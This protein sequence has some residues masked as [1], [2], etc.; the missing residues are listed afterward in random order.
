MPDQ[1]CIAKYVNTKSSPKTTL[2]IYDGHNDEDETLQQHYY[3]ED[4]ASLRVNYDGSDPDRGFTEDTP[5]PSVTG[6]ED[7][8]GHGD[9]DMPLY[10]V[11]HGS[12]M[13]VHGE[14]W[15]IVD[16][17]HECNFCRH[18]CTVMQCPSCKVQACAYCK[19]AY[20]SGE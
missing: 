13:E 20:R 15:D 9:W 6:E 12:H 2:P 5:E 17:E 7:D 16:S 11:P 10:S 3:H 1:P 4:R 19:D 18:I 8:C 14:F